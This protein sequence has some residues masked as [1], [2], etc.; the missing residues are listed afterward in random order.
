LGLRD[1]PDLLPPSPMRDEHPELEAL[2]SSLPPGTTIEQMYEQARYHQLIIVG[3]PGSGKT[4]LFLH[5]AQYLI[6]R[7]RKDETQPIPVILKL[8]LW[9]KKRL[10]LT[11]WLVKELETEYSIITQDAEALVRDGRLLLL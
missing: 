6:E 2:P 4:T 8:S 7:A 1:R 11:E 9:A 3:E 5:L 10:P